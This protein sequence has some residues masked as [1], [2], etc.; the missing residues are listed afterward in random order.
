MPTLS[1]IAG[2]PSTTLDDLEQE[3]VRQIIGVTGDAGSAT[4]GD[5]HTR[6]L[7]LTGQ[8]NQIVRVLIDQYLEDI[9]FDTASI[10]GG[11]NGVD[12]DPLRD[13]KGIAQELRR[14]IYGTPNP[15]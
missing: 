8:Q 4:W 15:D 11:S 10:S 12:Y 6:M 5:S 3:V 14:I 2:K 1:E 7:A 9:G 13:K